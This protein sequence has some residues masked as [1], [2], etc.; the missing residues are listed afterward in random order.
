M[1]L[2][3]VNYFR[4]VPNQWSAFSP[5]HHNVHSSTYEVGGSSSRVL[6]QPNF[7]LPTYQVQ[8]N[9][10]QHGLQNETRDFGLN[11]EL[12]SDE[13][14]YR[15]EGTNIVHSMSLALNNEADD[16]VDEHCIN[17]EYCESLEELPDIFDNEDWIENSVIE[18]AVHPVFLNTEE[19]YVHENADGVPANGGHAF[20]PDKIF[21]TK[22]DL[23]HVLQA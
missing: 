12:S 1:K 14:Q 8:D 19:G 4:R 6:P 11:A 13:D 15:E 9:L 7:D 18:D 16:N 22:E 20:W 5:Y 3:Y 21:P 23:V 17:N 10:E 2:K